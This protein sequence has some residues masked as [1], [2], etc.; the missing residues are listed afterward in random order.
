MG[1]YYKNYTIFGDRIIE[2]MEYITKKYVSG[3]WDTTY[4]SKNHNLLYRKINSLYGSLF[5]FCESFMSFSRLCHIKGKIPTD[6][7]KDINNCNKWLLFIKNKYDTSIISIHYSQKNSIK[8]EFNILVKIFNIWGVDEFKTGGCFH[9]YIKYYEKLKKG[10]MVTNNEK[11]V[12]QYEFD[13]KLIKK[14]SSRKAA[15]EVCG[16]GESDISMC[17]NGIIMTSGGFIWKNDGDELILS[18]HE[19]KMK[20]D[21]TVSQYNKESMF[22][23]KN[24][25]LIGTFKSF[26]EIGIE[27]GIDRSTIAKKFNK[28][29]TLKRRNG[30]IFIITPDNSSKFLINT[31]K[32]PKEASEKTGVCITSIRK[33]CIN[34]QETAGDF[35]WEYSN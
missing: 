22:L 18:D 21:V 33:C 8:K 17:C 29:E 35:R 34:Q 27:T 9:G 13:G 16:V 23:Y 15:S 7:F 6:H 2:R 20:K 10:E 31:Y 4:L 19:N 30:D 24:D 14:W 32:N 25:K 12:D 26:T 5:K 28:S 1:F 11:P 3:E